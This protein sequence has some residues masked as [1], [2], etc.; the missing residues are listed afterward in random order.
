M[1]NEDLNAVKPSASMELMQIARRKLKNGEQIVDL[2]GGEPD[3][4]TP[5]PICDEAVR[6]IN[7]GYTHYTVGPGL[8]ELREKIAYRL[9]KKK[10]NYNANGIIVTPGAKYAIYLAIK[11]LVSA[12]DEVMYLQPAW[13]SYEAI[14][15]LASAKPVPVK[16]N[17]A[18][19][20]KL[21]LDDLEKRVTKKTKALIINYPNTPTGKVLDAESEQ[22]LLKFLKSHKDILV[23][24]D[25]IYDE[26][27]YSESQN[28]RLASN[29]MI[30]DR[31][32][33]INGFSKS[34]AMTGWRLGYLAASDEIA[35]YIYKMFQ[36][37]ITC[38]SGFIMK[39][40]I[41][42]LDCNKELEYMRKEYEKRRNYFVSELNKIPN[43]HCNYPEGTFYAWVK[44]DFENI[45]PEEIYNRVINKA[46]I[47]GVP[48]SSYGEEKDICMRFSFATDKRN[49][50]KAIESLNRE[51]DKSV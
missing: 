28:F 42:A 32:I 11:S 10:C 24:S 38:V 18:N 7:N 3:F 49:L 31:V 23:I 50:E 22:I 39:A 25:E 13:V 9:K 8:E 33:T 26:I 44:F 21:N 19:G 17:Y 48:G 16:L 47:I 46:K 4:D 2:S 41:V 43:I 30:E 35:R 6:Q 45:S 12:G 5:R 40:G 15:L 29:K 14:I 1:Y 27:V 51:F 36:H 34:Y 20:Y 37:T